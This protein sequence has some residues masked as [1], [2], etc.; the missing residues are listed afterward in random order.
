MEEP[1]NNVA[2][3]EQKLVGKI[4]LEDD[5]EHTLNN[6][7]VVRIKDLPS[8]HRVLPPGAIMTRDYRLD[9]LNVFIDDNRKVER[10][11]YG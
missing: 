5:A 4:L 6:D 1:N 8:Y 11:Y 7:E 9:R 2:E 10:V 3:W